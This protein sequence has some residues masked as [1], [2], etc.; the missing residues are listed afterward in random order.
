MSRASPTKLFRIPFCCYCFSP[1]LNPNQTRQAN[2]ID[3]R[4]WWSRRTHDA[5]RH[6]C[7]AWSGQCR[8]AGNPAMTIWRLRCR[9]CRRFGRKSRRFCRNFLSPHSFLI[10][11]IHT[12]SEIQRLPARIRASPTG[13]RLTLADA[14]EQLTWPAVACESHALFAFAEKPLFSFSVLRLFPFG[15]TN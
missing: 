9:E 6:P 12:Y 10:R 1:S 8:D 14:M 5:M 3:D 11:P 2:R 7:P 13:K 4:V 15:R